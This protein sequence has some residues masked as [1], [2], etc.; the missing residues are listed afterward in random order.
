[1]VLVK[2]KPYKFNRISSQFSW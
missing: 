2:S 1:M